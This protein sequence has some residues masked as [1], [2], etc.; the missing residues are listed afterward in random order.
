MMKKKIGVS[1]LIVLLT[2]FLV[3]PFAIAL[4]LDLTAKSEIGD[5]LDIRVQNNLNGKT[6]TDGEFI[7]EKTDS[8]GKV[9]IN[10]TTTHTKVK[11][12]IIA[13]AS[14]SGLTRSF[15][16][17]P[18]IFFK[19][20]KTSGAGDTV[21]I[22]LTKSNPAV[23]YMEAPEPEVEE[24]PEEV[25]EEEPEEV[26]EEEPET[27]EVTEEQPAETTSGETAEAAS[28]A[29][30]QSKLLIYGVIILAVIII[31]PVVLLIIMKKINTNK[32]PKSIK[33]T[34]LSS[35]QQSFQQAQPQPSHLNQPIQ[36]QPP[37]YTQPVRASEAVQP[38]R[39][40]DDEERLIHDAEQRIRLAQEEIN[41]LKNKHK[42]R[43]A[44]KKLAEDQAE[45]ERLKG[46]Q[47]NLDRR[48]GRNDFENRL[49]K[50]D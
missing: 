50:S 38:A 26:A 4:S 49:Q 23:E 31:F 42:I 34:K 10:F 43:D 33:I 16:G 47:Q 28:S 14:G 39:T 17:V 45:L 24:E 32:P 36:R 1:V 44:E 2:M 15:N 20:V 30:F 6:F 27:T 46:S 13:R 35:A 37:Q 41:R 3:I 8:S 21:F 40:P 11:L 9:N 48:E 25:A 19:D 18:L 29:S 7:G 12:S 22:D 5:T